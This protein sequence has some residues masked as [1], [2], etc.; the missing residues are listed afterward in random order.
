MIQPRKPTRRYLA[1]SAFN[2]A[3]Q[4]PAETSAKPGPKP[5]FGFAMTAAER[6][7]KSRQNKKNLEQE[8]ERKRLVRELM[9]MYDVRKSAVIDTHRDAQERTYRRDFLREVITLSIDQL[10]LWIQNPDFDGRLWNERS[11]EGKRKHGASEIERIANKQD[12]LE[13]AESDPLLSSVFKVKPAGNGPDEMEIDRDKEK[14]GR[15]SGLSRPRLLPSTDEKWLDKTFEHFARQ[16][17]CPVCQQEFLTQTGA[18]YHLEEKYYDGKRQAQKYFEQSGLILQMNELMNHDP[19]KTLP[20][21]GPPN[22]TEIDHFAFI[23]DRVSFVKSLH[24]KTRVAI[25]DIG[26][27]PVSSIEST[28][29]EGFTKS[30]A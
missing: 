5:K 13:Q 30:V 12:V 11:G 26:R 3:P 22:T 27:T 28:T 8:T 25:R 21:P 1:G 2:P 7:R 16:S 19:R 29:S 20:M 14:S 4:E 24:R 9:K 6:Q 10:K 17:M 18:E 15:A 23:N